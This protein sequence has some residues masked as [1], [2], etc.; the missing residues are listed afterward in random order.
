VTATCNP[1]T[2]TGC[3]N[4]LLN[5][6]GR[7]LTTFPTIEESTPYGVLF[8][9]GLQTKLEHRTAH[10]LYL[11]NSFTWSHGIDNAS[12]H[13][14]ANDGDNSRVNL[15]NL[16]GERGNSGYNQP[17]NNTLSLVYD[18]PYG[19]GRMFGGNA[20]LALDEILGGWQV[21]AINDSN[22]GLPIN[23]TYSPNSFQSISTILNQRPNQAP[24]NP[25]L[26][27]SQRVRINGNQ[28][29]VT[30]Q[31]PVFMTV[32]NPIFSLPDVNHP[33]GNAGRNSVRFD[34]FYNTDIGL[35]KAFQ[36]YPENVSFDFRAEAFNV[37]NQTMYAFPSSGYSPSSTS[38]GV[39]A[40]ASTFPARVLQFAGKIIF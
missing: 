16:R 13:L 11:L 35:H 14:D 26:P 39:V 24:G 4:L 29:I 30:L 27:K 3:V 10:G 20:P 21:T 12:G 18:L 15:A 36:L 25:V 28:D 8:Y 31:N 33:Y 40:A 5:N 37:L 2:T 38:F 19:K 9:D 6:Q 1:T 7:P 17:W 34:S 32:S 23:I 22:A